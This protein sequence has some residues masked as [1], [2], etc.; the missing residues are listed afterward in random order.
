MEEPAC[1]AQ[2]P[3]PAAFDDL[4][5]FPQSVYS[6]RSLHPSAKQVFMSGT[7]PGISQSLYW[8]ALAL[9]PGLGP[10]RGRKLAEQFP[11]VE[12][13]FHASLTELEA[14]NLH[15]QSAQSI[16]LSKS[17]DSAPE[18]V[19]NALAARVQI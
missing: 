2:A 15:A 18:H 9:T 4:T 19:A 8:L 13:I 12:D 6:P 14:L 17:L 5:L 7:S 10:T 16:A 3:S 1:G 11:S